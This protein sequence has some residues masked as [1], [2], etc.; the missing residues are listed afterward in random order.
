MTSTLDG[1]TTLPHR[2]Q[3][4]AKPNPEN[5][6][7]E[8]DFLI[9][10]QLA[11][12]EKNTPYFYGGDNNYLVTSFLTPGEHSFTVHMVTTNGQSVD[13]IDKA[14]VESAP[15]LPNGLADSSWG[16]EVT[17]S[18]VQK[19]TSSAPPPAG[20]WDLTINSVGWM[21]HDPEG[22]GL[23]L[24]VDYQSGGKVEL[25]PTIEQPPYPNPYTGS[26]CKEPDPTALWIYTFDTS[27]KT[28]SLHPVDKDICGDRLAILEG[29][30]AIS[31]P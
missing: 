11:W 16:R 29:T 2:I 21:V 22:G 27:G 20:Q 13:S 5:N 18:D 24:D 14:S 4:E 15:V 19:A 17:A 7:S 8:V 9:D 25:R 3:W 28:L 1:L 23:L 31:V 12:V 30:W 26:F 10:G 6:V